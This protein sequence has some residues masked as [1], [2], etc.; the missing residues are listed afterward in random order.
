MEDKE[1]VIR[2]VEIDRIRP[3]PY[4]P[5]K[6]FNNIA[7]E[8]LALSIKEYGVLQP[9]VLKRM[10]EG[11]FELIAGERRVKAA[12]LAGLEDIPAVVIEIRDEDSAIIALIENLQREDLNF[13]E[14]AE[15]YYNLMNDYGLTQEQVARKVGKNQSTIANKIRLLRLPQKV[16]EHIIQNGLTERHARALLK[17]PEQEIQITLLDRIA[18]KNLRVKETEELVDRILDKLTIREDDQLNEEIN[19]K[20]RG[21][22]NY[23]IYINTVRNAYRAIVQ[24]GIQAEFSQRDKGEYIEVTIKIPKSA[25]ASVR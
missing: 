4:Q 1:T 8:E 18:E 2:K 25:A 15:G 6:K 24:S 19:K 23:R 17:I 12:K 3:N 11:Y 7:I 13:F 21:T 16:R 14:E 5:R 20:I 10:N 9:I 22:I